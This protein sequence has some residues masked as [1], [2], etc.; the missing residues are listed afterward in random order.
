MG[1]GLSEVGVGGWGVGL[2][3]PGGLA[4]SLV[5]GLG[6]SPQSWYLGVVPQG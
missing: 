2:K 4:V 6:C 1:V 5:E 3:L